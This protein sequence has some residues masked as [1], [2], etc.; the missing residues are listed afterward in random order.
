[1][2][3]L[4]PILL[5]A[6]VGGCW[7]CNRN[8]KATPDTKSPELTEKERMKKEYEGSVSS[9][10]F[11]NPDPKPQSAI[12]SKDSAELFKI[13]DYVT[14]VE[15][16][17]GKKYKRTDLHQPIFSSSDDHL[18]YTTD[19]NK[20]IEA[21]TILKNGNDRERH[22]FYFKE[23][24]KVFYRHLEIKKDGVLPFAKETIVF[25]R[26]DEIFEVQQRMLDLQFGDNPNRL[27]G[28]PFDRPDVDKRIIQHDI[29]KIWDIMF[30]AIENH[31]MGVN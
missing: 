13:D 19:V 14:L 22:Y 28:K 15:S 27:L 20:V 23:N 8:T 18:F 29:E 11:V 12:S 6:L 24:T 1:M 2:R 10:N 7:A 25:F 31:E 9:G 4:F 16:E 26:D 5:I 17:R 21:I 30:R 3:V